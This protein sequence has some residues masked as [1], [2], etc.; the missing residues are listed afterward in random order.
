MDKIFNRGIRINVPATR[1]AITVNGIAVLGVNSALY[2]GNAAKTAQNQVRGRLKLDVRP[3]GG[4]TEDYALQ[5]RSIS[6]KTTGSHWGIDSETHLGAS[7]AVGIMGVRGV[8]VVDAT[9]TDTAVTLIG[10]YGQ[11]RADGNVAGASFMTGVYGLVEDS[12]AITASHVASIW[13][14]S[15]MAHAVTGNHELIYMSNNGST[16]LDQMVY[17]YGD[18]DFLLNISQGNETVLP[19]YVTDTATTAGASKKIAVKINGTVYYINAYAG[20]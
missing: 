10:V 2:A 5:I 1:N 4:T 19:T 9:F 8:A 7:G 12:A 15:H 14:D 17:A 6:G 3:T 20:S 16:K 13:A 11:V 18:A